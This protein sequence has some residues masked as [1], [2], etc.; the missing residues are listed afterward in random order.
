[1]RKKKQLWSLTVLSSISDAVMVQTKRGAS[2]LIMDGHRFIR[3]KIWGDGQHVH[4]VCNMKR[5]EGCKVTVLTH[6]EDVLKING[7]HYHDAKQ[8]KKTKVKK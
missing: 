7:E 8:R 4:W 6:K 2:Q 5:K 1:M 3:N